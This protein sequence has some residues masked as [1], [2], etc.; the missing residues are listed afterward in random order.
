ML[1]MK[2][3]ALWFVSIVCL[4]SC[5]TESRIEQVSLLPLPTHVSLSGKGYAFK[6]LSLTSDASLQA[7]INVLQ[8]QFSE[9]HSLH[10]NLETE[11]EAHIQVEITEALPD[12]IH[13]EGYW[14]QIQGSRATVKSRSAAG[15][16]YGLQTIRQLVE[17]TADGYRWP[18]LEI[19]DQP[20]LIVRGYL[21]DEARYFQG[22]DLVKRMLDEMSRLKMNTFIWHLVDDQGWRIHIDALPLLTAIGSKRD[23]TQIP[24]PTGSKWS[25]GTWDGKPHAGFYTKDQIREIIAYAAARH[26]Q[27][28]P[29]IEMPGH[30]SA[31]I[32]AYPYLSVRKKPITVPTTFGVKYETFDVSDPRTIAFL[33]QVLDEV[34]AL[35]PSKII[36]IGGDEVKFDHWNESPQIQAYMKA[37]QI[38]S[39]ADLQVYFTNQISNYISSKGKRMMGW[40]DILGVKLHEYNATDA[41]ATGTLDSNTIIH[42]WKGD[43]QLL[44][45]AA[46]KGYDIVNAH[47]EYTYLDYD[48]QTTPLSKTYGFD[49]IPADLPAAYHKNVIGICTQMWGEFTPDRTYIYKMAFPRLA[50]VAE[51][52]WTAAAL[53]DWSSFEKRLQPLE[54][55]WEEVLK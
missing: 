25:A 7:S 43:F 37:R 14:L 33:Q 44:T 21:Q 12:S 26:I 5:K 52:G 47:H 45:D 4:F 16:F 30:A 28:I 51:T 38:V 53:K 50:A 46:K 10:L 20:R 31:A 24:P 6:T 48:L 1:R 9:D 15:I 18:S 34:M 41:P 19:V 36:H 27:I 22:M 3:V 32:A 8:S 42:F 23:S 11:A 13:G 40:N 55:R 49:P 39:A 29:E 35:F 17:K 54:A 2:M